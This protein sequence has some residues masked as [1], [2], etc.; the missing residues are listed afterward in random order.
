MFE[1]KVRRTFSGAHLLRDY[2]GKC[3][4]MHGHN[5]VVYLVVRGRQLQSNGMLLDFKSLKATLNRALE[6]VDHKF[7]ND[8]PPFDELNP[9]CE[10]LARFIFEVCDE[11]L[12]RH[13]NPDAKM[14]RVEVW[15]TETSSA[16]YY[17]DDE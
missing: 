17:R 12:A 15:E 13:E 16:T 8:V 7:L 5:W 14:H 6:L 10:H 1:L 9:S 4:N 11:H 3:E 2:R